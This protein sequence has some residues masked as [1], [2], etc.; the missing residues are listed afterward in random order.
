MDDDDEVN[1]L[2]AAVSR[3]ACGE[4]D[5]NEHSCRV[6]WFVITSEVDAGAAEELRGLLN[7]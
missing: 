3:L 2:A 6:P 5:F 4:D 7:R 1:A